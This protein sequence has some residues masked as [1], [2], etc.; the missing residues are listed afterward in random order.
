[1]AQQHA[2]ALF[3]A[4]H[5]PLAEG[6]I[7]SLCLFLPHT[8]IGTLMTGITMQE[9]TSLTDKTTLLPLAALMLAGAVAQPALAQSSADKD[10]GTILIQDKRDGSDSKGVLRVRETEI[11]KG[12]QAL[13]DNTGR[14]RRNPGGGGRTHPA[15]THE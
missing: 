4:S 5:S 12:R 9:N 15:G 8:P 6:V 10:M 7:A 2:A 11:G 13:R 3:L 14:T 1:M